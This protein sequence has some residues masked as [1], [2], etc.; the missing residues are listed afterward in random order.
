MHQL[1]NENKLDSIKYDENILVYSSLK[2]FYHPV[3]SQG[4]AVKYVLEGVERYTLNGRKYDIKAGK[5]LLSNA[6]TEGYVEIESHKSVKGICINITPEVL[7]E[8]AATVCR[9]D[10]P[11]SDIEMGQFFSSALFLENCYDAQRTNLGYLLHEMGKAMDG[12]DLLKIDLN[13]EFFYTISEKIIADQIPIFKQLQAIP[14]IKS[15]TKKELFRCISKGKEYI[16]AHF[17]MPLTIEAIAKEVCMSEYHFFRLFKSVYGVSPHQYILKKRLELGQNILI[18][19]KYSISDAAYESG[20]SD[21]F[22]FSKA[23]KKHFGYS[24]SSLL[25]E[26]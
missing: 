5:Y 2:E 21:I 13:M 19:D 14:S 8:V 24:P 10:T 25:K 18:Q 3:K 1:S 17:F 23:F 15:V 12:N 26:K 7:S 22:A 6:T 9:P 20:F 11:F 4:F 16:D